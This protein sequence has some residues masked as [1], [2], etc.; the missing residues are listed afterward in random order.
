MEFVKGSIDDL[1]SLG[2]ADK[3]VDVVIS[4]CVINLTED[5]QK[6]LSEVH[7]V[8]KEGGELFFS[9]V[10]AD[11]RIPKNLQDDKVLWGECLSGALYVEDFR[12]IMNNVGFPDYR[13]TKQHIITVNNK[14]IEEV[15]GKIIFYSLNVRAFKIASL[16]DRCEDYEQTATYLGTLPYEKEEFE[17]DSSHTFKTNKEV[18]VCKNTA[19]MLA[20]TRFAEHFRVTEAG[21][22]KGLFDCSTDCCGG[23][24]CGSTGQKKQ[25]DESKCTTGGCSNNG[26]GCC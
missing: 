4:N 13:F 11:R 17:L 2:I 15:V 25:V 16:E 14:K 9:D 24:G 18:K 7:R 6:V 21:S 20:K 10:Y 26:G 8:L 3:S 23:E 1:K 19:D 12:R 5:K 22:H